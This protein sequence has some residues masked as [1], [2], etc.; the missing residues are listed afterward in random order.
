M[1]FLTVLTRALRIPIQITHISNAWKNHSWNVILECSLKTTPVIQLAKM[2][3]AIT[4]QVMVIVRVIAVIVRVMVTAL[5]ASNSQSK[6][7]LW[8]TKITSGLISNLKTMDASAYSINHNKTRWTSLIIKI[9]KRN[10]ISRISSVRLRN[11]KTV[12]FMI[13]LEIKF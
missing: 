1:L 5:I 3:V 8:Q 7:S 13:I 6:T 11:T 2:M 4:V 9:F 10:R 12:K